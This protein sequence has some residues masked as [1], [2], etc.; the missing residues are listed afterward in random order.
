MSC[1]LLYKIH[2]R[3]IISI[4]IPNFSYGNEHNEFLLLLSL[5]QNPSSVISVLIPNFSYGNEHSEFLLLL[6]LIQNPS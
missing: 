2:L 1:D 4:L 3:L 6:S 5:I